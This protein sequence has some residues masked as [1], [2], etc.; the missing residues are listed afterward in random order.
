NFDRVAVRFST[1]DGK[2]WTDPE[3]IAVD[4]MGNHLARPFD[5]TLVPLPDGRLRLY[6]TSNDRHDSRFAMSPPAIY[7]AVTSDGL[8]YIFEPGVRFSIEGRITIDCAAALHEGVYHLFVPDNGTA[9]EME[10]NQRRH[11]PPRGGTGYHA[12]SRDGLN[13]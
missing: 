2:S 1:D 11:E 10:E 13:F 8:H 9:A 6:F 5:P 4:G 12:V 7:S 3:P